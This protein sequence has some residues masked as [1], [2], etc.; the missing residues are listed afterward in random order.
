MCGVYSYTVRYDDELFPSLDDFLMDRLWFIEHTNYCLII[1]YK[2]NLKLIFFFQS[3]TELWLHLT[4][5]SKCYI[6]FIDYMSEKNIDVI[7]FTWHDSKSL[8]FNVT[9]SWLLEKQIFVFCHKLVMIMKKS[10]SSPTVTTLSETWAFEMAVVTIM[11]SVSS[12]A[13]S[14]WI[15]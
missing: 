7:V 8:V 2:L 12:S 3:V 4:K 6:A 1:T 9:S 14:T 15:L 10:V 5:K 11:T 13:W